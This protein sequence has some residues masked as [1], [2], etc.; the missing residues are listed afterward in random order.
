MIRLRILM[1]FTLAEVLITLGIIGIVAAMT[2][3]TLV[4]DY[5]KKQYITALQKEYNQFSQ[6]LK[7]YM[8]DQGATELGQTDLFDG[9][10]FSSAGRQT[11]IDDMV[12]KYFNTVRTCK[13]GDTTCEK[14]GYKYLSNNPVGGTVFSRMGY[15]FCTADGACF[16]INSG[17]PATCQPDYTKISNMK[18]NCGTIA[19]DTNGNQPPNTMGKDYFA[20]AL[21]HDGT[22]FPYYGINYSIFVDGDNLATSTSYWK[23]HAQFCGTSGS[24]DKTG[25]NGDGCAA[26]VIEETWQMNY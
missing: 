22:L 16:A 15:T 12:R 9:T 5:Q 18:A 6:G 7:L 13:R 20:F 19:M 3:P 25:V 1:A 17:F 14:T 24:D 2:I 11:K 23:N 21:G 10:A 8:A 26:R 4:A